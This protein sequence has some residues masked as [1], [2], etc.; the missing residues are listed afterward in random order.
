MI[1][2]AI[3]TDD[4][5]NVAPHTGR[6]RGFAVYDLE[7]GKAVK[8]EF[9]PNLFTAHHLAHESGGQHQHGHGHSHAGI[10]NGLSDCQAMIAVGMGRRLIDDLRAVGMRVFYA[11]EPGLQSVA[12][13]AAAG[14]LKE[15]PLDAACRG[16]QHGQ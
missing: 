11:D 5:Q 10:L 15:I 4:E 7:E 3:P 8:V 12:Q 2:I 6:C 1:R 13:K 16:H 9:R 14:E